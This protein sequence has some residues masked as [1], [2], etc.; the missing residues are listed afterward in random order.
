[1]FTYYF[2]SLC[3]HFNFYLNSSTTYFSMSCKVMTVFVI[4]LFCRIF[5]TTYIQSTLCGHGMECNSM[6]WDATRRAKP[7]RQH[8]R[9]N[10]GKKVFAWTPKYNCVGVNYVQQQNLL[11]VSNYIGWSGGKSK[12]FLGELRTKNLKIANTFLQE[13]AI[14][15]SESRKAWRVFHNLQFTD[16]C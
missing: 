16:E 7:N 11:D 2:F 12:G 15:C 9:W 1:M 5:I 10:P 6:E 8:P 3:L 14:G 4:Y 13:S